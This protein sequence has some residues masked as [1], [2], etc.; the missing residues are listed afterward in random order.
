MPNQALAA[1]DAINSESD[2]KKRDY[3]TLIVIGGIGILE[4][5]WVGFL[6]WAALWILGY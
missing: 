6:G 3:L 1:T 2:G 5:G 4:L